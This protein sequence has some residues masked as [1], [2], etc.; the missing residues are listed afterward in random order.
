MQCKHLYYHRVDGKLLCA[1]CGEAS[2]KRDAFAPLINPIEDKAAEKPEDKALYWPP[3]AKR[4]RGRPK[5]G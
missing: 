2:P 5:R 1:Q 3:E 4:L